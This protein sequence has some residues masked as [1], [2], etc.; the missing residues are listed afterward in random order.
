M[1]EPVL[2][3]VEELRSLC[4]KAAVAA[5]AR[6][7]QAKSLAYAAVEAERRGRSLLGVE[8]FFDY[9]A[10]FRAGRIRS[11][12]FPQ[13]EKI[14]SCAFRVNCHEGLAQ[15]GFEEAQPLLAES[16]HTEG[17]SMLALHSC[18]P[19]GELGHYVRE[20]A[21]YDLMSLVFGNTNA[22]VAAA[23]AKRP[24]V[25]TNPLAFGLHL[26]T[27]GLLLIDQASSA[28]AWVSVRK[29]ADRGETV[30]SGWAIDSSGHPT[31]SPEEALLGGLLPF[32][33]YKGGNVAL[34]VEM[35]AV[36]AGGQFSLDSAS[37]EEGNTPPRLGLMIIAFSPDKLS[38]G[39]PSRLEQQLQRWKS[40]HEADCRRWFDRP[41]AETVTLSAD[42]Y[43]RLTS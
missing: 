6:Q 32:G 7:S 26:P 37:F 27:A 41:A 36:M 35:L 11:D 1:Y 39:F 22:M 18:F 38:P 23:S 24:I 20:L 43:G 40:V 5:G 28:T 10:G 25:G 2:L 42:T 8:H 4:T 14:S 15:E 17:L 29:A 33:G 34:L 13:I 31:T 30:P 19:G 21:K 3:S 12:G 16:A 9:L